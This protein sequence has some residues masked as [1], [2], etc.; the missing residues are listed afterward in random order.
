MSI[1]EELIEQLQGDN[2]SLIEENEKLCEDNIAL[3]AEVEKLRS[4]IGNMTRKFACHSNYH[5]DTIVSLLTCAKEGKEVGIARPLEG[6]A[7]VKNIIDI[8]IKRMSQKTGYIL[9]R[10]E[11]TLYF[12]ELDDIKEIGEQMKVDFG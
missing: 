1:S 2:Y 8:F 6:Y 9:D 5:G 11:H 7:D 3:Q 10:D 12:V 4:F